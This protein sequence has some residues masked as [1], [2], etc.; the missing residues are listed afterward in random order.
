MKLIWKLLRQHINLSQLLGFTFANLLGVLIILLGIQFYN[1]IQAIYNGTDSFMKSDYVILNKKVGTLSSFLGS[2]DGFTQSEISDIKKQSFVEDLGMFSSSAFEV[3][4]SFNIKGMAKFSTEMFFESVPDKFVD[5]KS[6]QWAFE[7][8]D[9]HLPIILPRNYL[10]LYNFGFAQTKNLPKLS[11]GL[12]GM[13]AIRITVSGN[14]RTDYYNGRIIGFSSRINTILV[15]QSF[16]DFAN[17][18]YAPHHMLSNPTRIIIKVGNPADERL[19]TYLSQHN[20]ITDQDK[21][22]AS[23]TSFL[24]RVIIGVVM[25]IG[26]V[27]CILSFYILMLS[28]YLLVQKNSDKLQNLLLLGYS[29]TKVALPYQILTISLNFSVLI[30][31]LT[32]L[33]VVR[34]VYVESFTSYFPDFVAASMGPTIFIGANLFLIVSFINVVVVNRRIRNLK[35]AS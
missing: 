26:G 4:A 10:D 13:L 8:G 27:I 12:I 11:E 30:L 6:D 32:I 21:L 15:P 3:N 28:V 22:D 16:M 19:N 33:F 24:L 18:A 34:I 29:V 23:K 7:E 9:A 5:V 17:V 1:D 31:A 35:S 25:G 2:S 20:Y 14:G